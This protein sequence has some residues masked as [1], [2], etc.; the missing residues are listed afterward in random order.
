MISD[1][2]MLPALAHE[3]LELSLAA[4]LRASTL[5]RDPVHSPPRNS[6]SGTR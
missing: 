3:N 6:P 2:F 4:V 5:H 1:K